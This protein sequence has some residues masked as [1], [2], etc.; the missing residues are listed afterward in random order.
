[1]TTV[2]PIGA[3]FPQAALLDQPRFDGG[4]RLLLDGA[5]ADASHLA[6]PD[7]PA[8]LEQPDVLRKKDGNAISNDL[9]RLLTL[10]GPL[11]RAPEHRPPRG[12]G[13][14]V[15]NAVKLPRI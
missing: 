5:D 3:P 7:P 1:M 9:A 2:E 14:R 10:T 11:L 13:K 15:E 6:R 4:E 8:R 12:I